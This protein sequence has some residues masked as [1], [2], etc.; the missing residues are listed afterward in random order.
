MEN[1]NRFLTHMTNATHN[2]YLSHM[3]DCTGRLPNILAAFLDSGVKR[4]RSLH[5][6]FR[7][8]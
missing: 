8:L 1:Y 4:S 6:R 5:W 7:A 2:L 3:C